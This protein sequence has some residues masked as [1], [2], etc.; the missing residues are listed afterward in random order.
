MWIADVSIRRPVFALMITIALTAL[1]LVSLG[2]VG[3]DLFPKV[4]APFVSVT[5]KLE[6]A[7]AETIEQEVTDVVEE[8][9]NTIGGIESLRSTS[10]EGLSQVF[11]EFELTESLEEKAQDV[12]DKVSRALADLPRDV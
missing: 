6:G 4:E 11:V 3:V 5:T 9:V 10:S 12:R 7:S 2:R 1:G 8:Y